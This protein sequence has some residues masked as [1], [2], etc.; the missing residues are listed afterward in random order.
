[1]ECLLHVAYRLDVKCWQVRKP[2][3]KESVADRKKHIQEAFKNQMGL[4]I[5]VP[6]QGSGSSNDGNTAR[7]F[8]EEPSVSAAI[9]GLD[10]EMVEKFSVILSVIAS[11]F[12]IHTDKF[13]IYCI[14]TAKQFVKLYGW[15]KMPSSVHR[16]LVHGADVIRASII[17]VGT[18]SEEP[19]ECRNKDIK[20]FR[21]NRARKCSR[22][23]F[24]FR[25]Y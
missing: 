19:Q 25:M 20:N 7:R 12:E 10:V 16:V 3:D 21:E 23:V 1:M 9:T 14:E 22:Y 24:D 15:Y 8:F 13:Q 11:G 5:D 6:K 2:H 17:P 18:L 4:I